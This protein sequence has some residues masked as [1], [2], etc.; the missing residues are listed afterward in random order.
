MK[1][2]M[3]AVIMHGF[4]AY[5]RFRWRN[6][7]A[8]DGAGTFTTFNKIILR[9]VTQAFPRCRSLQRGHLE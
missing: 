8:I 5:F 7:A 9:L 6:S 3:A 2:P 4:F 1:I